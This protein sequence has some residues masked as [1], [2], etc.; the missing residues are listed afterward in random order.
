MTISQ[1]IASK[2]KDR[3]H[4]LGISKQ[5]F[6]KMVCQQ[7]SAITKWLSGNHN[8]TIQ[9]IE[10]IQVALKV[11]FFSY[12]EE[13]YGCFPCIVNDCITLKPIKNEYSI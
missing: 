7:P 12:T 2:I 5:E 6:A 10:Q 9:T 3:L 8:F 13:K 4:A 11:S 1:F